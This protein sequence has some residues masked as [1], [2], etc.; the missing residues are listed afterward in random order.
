LELNG[1]HQ[2]LGYVDVN[3]LGEYINSIKETQELS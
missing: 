3:V 2:L 1:T